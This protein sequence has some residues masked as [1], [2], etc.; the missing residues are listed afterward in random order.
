MCWLGKIKILVILIILNK[1]SCGQEIQMFAIRQ[2]DCNTKCTSGL[3]SNV[4]K[5]FFNTTVKLKKD[6]QKNSIVRFEI[7]P[8]TSME[9]KLLFSVDINSECTENKKTDNYYHCSK[10][11]EDAYNI[12]IYSQV[13][14]LFTE[15]SIRGVIKHYNQTEMAGDEIK[16]PKI[17]E[18]TDVTGILTVNGNNITDEDA[19]KFI[20]DKDVLRIDIEYV[21]MGQ[22]TPCL[23]EISSNDSTNIDVG[24]NR[25][26]FKRFLYQEI[27]INV[28]IKYALCRLDLAY[29]HM[30]CNVTKRGQSYQRITLIIVICT[31]ILTLIVFLLTIYSC[32]KVIAN[33]RK[34]ALS[35][36]EF[37]EN[38][39]EL[40]PLNMKGNKN[41]P[42][43]C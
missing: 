32:F 27:T 17:V 41:P 42:C 4:D 23:I 7:M 12:S 37:A 25:A 39:D 35:A 9:F 14:P 38:P 22:A 8:K 18:P 26:V 16:L 15:A 21:C 28:K 13:L 33:Q 20:I 30:E 29:K 31:G 11:S 1:F 24:E 40:D 43:W 2:E 5:I 34:S 6:L 10:I 36:K 19:C 3:I